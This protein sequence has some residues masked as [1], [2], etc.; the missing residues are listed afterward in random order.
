[1]NPSCSIFS[2]RQVVTRNQKVNYLLSIAS[3][4]LYTEHTHMHT[5]TCNCRESYFQRFLFFIPV[6][7]AFWSQ[8]LK[9]A[10]YSTWTPT[11][12]LSFSSVTAS[13]ELQWLFLLNKLHKIIFLLYILCSRI[14]NAH[15]YDIFIIHEKC[16]MCINFRYTKCIQLFLYI[17]TEESERE[18]CMY[19]KYL[20]LII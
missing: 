4:F 16:I 1:M 15:R 17:C 10:I 14:R 8:L 9:H 3:I 13:M 19:I 12:D 5:P 11:R 7:K 20:F 6:P 2:Q 18:R